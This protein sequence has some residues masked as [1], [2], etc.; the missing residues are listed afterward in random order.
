[1]KKTYHN[2]NKKYN[3][4]YYKKE[5]DIT[6]TIEKRYNLLIGIIILM[7]AV[8]GIGLFYVQVVQN[9]YYVNK[10]A[11]LSQK[12][13]YSTSTP[14]GRIYDRNGKL[15]VDNKPVK[16][17]YYKK[18]NGVTTKQEIQYAYMVAQLLSVSYDKMPKN[19]LKEF[20][21]LNHTE[22]AKNKITAEEWKQLE[23]RKL[24]Q[25]DIQNL[26]VERVTEEEISQYQEIDLK[27][28][29]IYYLMNTGYSYDEKVIK[30]IDVTD[31]E[32]AIIAENLSELPGFDTKLD[33]ER[34]YPYGNVF[35]TIL[36]SVSTQKSGIPYELKDYYL[37]KGYSLN[38]RVGTSYIEYQ[39]ED[40][41]KGVKS[42]YQILT[43]GTS[44][45]L[46]EGSRGKDI[47]LTIDIELQ[48]AVEN[49]IV[50]HLLGARQEAN[51][52]Y[53]DKSFVII[54]NPNTGEILAMAGKQI[55]KTETGY[56]VYDYTPG[57]TTAP[58]VIGSAVKGASH[59]VGYNTGALSIGERRNDECI[60]IA[61]TPLKCSW[62]NTLGIIN[63][64]EA[65]RQS[66]NVFQF[67]TAI[68]VGKGYYQYD[69]PLKLDPA[70]FDIYR[71]TFAQFGLGVK[72]E[73]DLPV[74]SLGYKGDSTLS[75][76]L[77]DFSIGQ[78]DT[79]TP[80]QLSQY[81]NTIANGGNRIK[82][83]LL[84][85]VYE[86]TK[87]PLINLIETT[88][89]TILN[90]LDTKPEYLNRVKEGFKAV[91]TW[92]GTG[93]GYVDLAFKPAGKTGTSQSFIDTNGDGVVDTETLTNTFVAYAPYDN[94]TVTFT[95]LSPNISHYNGAT[96][97][98]SRVNRRLSYAISSKY[99]E[100]YPQ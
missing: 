92:G 77:L 43:D 80:I 59:I 57:I 63:D 94:P 46:E 29:Y 34:E 33:W 70:A 16:V 76:H 62:T 68:R 49:I 54:S 52:E 36:G 6:I 17:I 60:K 89:T 73:I 79:Y 99:F 72:T 61:A 85:A 95:V 3:Y 10:I 74:E 65:L 100:F 71:N 1:M 39:Y 41:L 2:K 48:K 64:V 23:E 78:Y 67:L 42:K 83:Y 82:P 9:K 86:P 51:T 27:A 75:G 81:V 22:E 32:Y 90:T 15:I 11:E 55:V 26:K 40:I 21:L 28:A 4:N 50:E 24:S 25:S 18:P 12:I 44:I 96:N 47:M 98:Q 45:L 87:E 66:S 30:D 91:M 7:V 37:E 31:E 20:W 56:D 38:D 88:Q 5:K 14:R 53:Y 13:V 8:L 69:Q 93:S 35:K 19:R 58:V 97:F 84:K